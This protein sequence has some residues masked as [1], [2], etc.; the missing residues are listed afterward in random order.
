MTG[1]VA[2]TPTLIVCGC[3]YLIAI[4]SFFGG[5]ILDV[6]IQKDRQRFELDLNSFKNWQRFK[7][8]Q[9]TVSF[10]I[11]KVKNNLD[12]TKSGIL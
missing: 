1:L 9:N 8:R 11:T 6:I 4:H 7:I 10:E 3:L 12:E 5:L 2:K